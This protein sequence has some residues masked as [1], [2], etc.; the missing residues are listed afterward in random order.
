MHAS[1]SQG[2]GLA[3][4]PTPTP[5]SV[6]GSSRHPPAAVGGRPGVAACRRT[7]RRARAGRAA[8]CRCRRPQLGLARAPRRCAPRPRARRGSPRTSHRDRGARGVAQRVRQALLHDAVG[9]PRRPADGQTS[10][11]RPPGAASRRGRCRRRARPAPRRARGRAPGRSASSSPSSATRRP[12]SVLGLAGGVGDARRTPRRVRSGST[13]GQP[14]ARARLHDHDADRVGDDVVQL[15]RDPR[16]LVA[17]RQPRVRLALLRRARAARSASRAATTLAL[18]QRTARGPADGGEQDE[19][20]R[21]SSADA[22]AGRPRAARRPPRR[23]PRRASVD[24]S[25]RRKRVR[26]AAGPRAVGDRPVRC[27]RASRDRHRHANPAQRG[28]AQDAERRA[29]QPAAEAS[30]ARAV[31]LQRRRCQPRGR[32]R[33]ADRAGQPPAH[34]RPPRAPAGTRRPRRARPAGL[35]RAFRGAAPR[36]RAPARSPPR[37][38]AARAARRR[39]ARARRRR[40]RRVTSTSGASSS[41]SS[42]CSTI[43]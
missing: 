2:D 40:S 41:A 30:A 43:R 23:R 33:D 6:A 22:C 4:P 14:L 34:L 8:R 5:R 21:P 26:R 10:R 7:R 32:R 17:D 24:P 28:A 11:A 20:G 39:R 27:R 36:A 19:P 13:R 3:R 31:G 25:V 37:R 18:A 1:P 42:R 16:A 38:A 9:R 15:R 29:E 12:M 35:G